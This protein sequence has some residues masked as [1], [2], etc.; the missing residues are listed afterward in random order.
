M[1][2]GFFMDEVPAFLVWWEKLSFFRYGWEN[3]AV[4]LWTRVPTIACDK[5]GAVGVDANG[6]W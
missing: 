5:A 3:M 4:S 1:Y 2:G 6:V